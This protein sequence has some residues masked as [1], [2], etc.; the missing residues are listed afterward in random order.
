MLP[1]GS[2][3]AAA[4]V[5][6]Q[7]LLP[8]TH[9]QLHSGQPV[10]ASELQMGDRLLSGHAQAIE[11]IGSLWVAIR[12]ELSSRSLADL[13]PKTPRSLDAHHASNRAL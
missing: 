9:V 8:G 7:C 11:A 12:L 6:P 3:T 2:A 1:T 10:E 4:L 5:T 13:T